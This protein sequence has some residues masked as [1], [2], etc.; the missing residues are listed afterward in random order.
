MEDTSRE[1]RA[2][3]HAYWMTLPVEERLRRCG[4]MFALAKRFAENRAPAGLTDE[5]RK[6]FVFKQLYGSEMPDK[7]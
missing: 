1:I 3:Q 6:R 2:V 4:E 5:E 7:G